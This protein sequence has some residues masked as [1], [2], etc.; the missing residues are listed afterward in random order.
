MQ[1]LRMVETLKNKWKMIEIIISFIRKIYSPWMVYL[2]LIDRHK[3]R[4]TER[5]IGKKIK[6][7]KERKIE[8][9]IKM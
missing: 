8:N 3:D 9:R 1:K 7:Q 2:Q 4:I 5:L 6:M